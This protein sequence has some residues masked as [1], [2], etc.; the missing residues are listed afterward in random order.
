MYR[1]LLIAC[2]SMQVMQVI[3]LSQHPWCL[4]LLN[5][6]GIINLIALPGLQR[7]PYYQVLQSFLFTVSM[8]SNCCC[9]HCGT[10]HNPTLRTSLCCSHHRYLPWGCCMLHHHNSLKHRSHGCFPCRKVLDYSYPLVAILPAPICCHGQP[11]CLS[12]QLCATID[13]SGAPLLSTLLPF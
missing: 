11:P 9:F 10:V 2:F 1:D 3:D 4:S 12:K 5:S 13:I 8:S 7:R 6:S